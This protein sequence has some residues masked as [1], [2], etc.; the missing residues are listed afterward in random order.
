MMKP[1]IPVPNDNRLYTAEQCRRLDQRTI[2][3]F[4]IDGFTLMEIAAR[5]AASYI[6]NELGPHKTGYFV[7]GKG[8]NCGDALAVARYLSEFSQHSITVYL[9][10]GDKDL[11]PDARK[12]LDLLRNLQDHG[13]DITFTD[14]LDLLPL[15][16][17]D[18][19]VD[20]IFGTGLNSDL[21]PPLPGIIETICEARRPVYAM[22]VP[23]GLNADTG[24]IH[25]HC[26]RADHTITFGLNKLGFYLGEGQKYT[27]EVSRIELPFPGYL[28][29]TAPVLINEK[30]K[31]YLPAASREARHKYESG[32]VH[33]LA[34][35]EGLTG[36]AIMAAKSAWKQGAGAV[37]LYT[38]KK[39]LSVFEITLPHIIKIPLGSSSDSRLTSAHTE[40]IL[41]HLENKKGVLIAGPGTGTS[42]ETGKCLY[43]IL[44]R[45]TGYAVID[46]DALSFWS[47]LKKISSGQK[48]KWLLTP[49]IGEAQKYLGLTFENDYDRLKKTSEFSARHKCS[50]LSKGHPTIFVSVSGEI[51]ISGYNTRVFSRAGFG[52][53]LSGTIGAKIGINNEITLST[54][55]ALYA[56][57]STYHQ[58]DP[59]GPFGPEHLT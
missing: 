27:G 14:S 15:V 6:K 21:R 31:T 23:S 46:A 30:L 22:D 7:C 13:S 9:V 28:R 49:H 40:T 51:Y 12:N 39:L 59:A 32:V 33:I 5:G 44:S 25:G 52:D 50:L 16:Q 41:Q 18:Y 57:I 36:A 17:A 56:G 38:P 42:E 35:S 2:T 37:F 34:G 3:D 53:V 8:N 24:R 48:K 47:S 43:N 29:E 19:I 55:S 10:F 11:S 20:G 26:I 58:T 54:V 4:G 45:Y 1:A